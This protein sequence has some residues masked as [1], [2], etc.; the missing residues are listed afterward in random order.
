MSKLNKRTLGRS[1]IKVSPLGLGCWPIGGSFKFGGGRESSYGTVNDKE[2]IKAIQRA[3][4]LGVNFFDT[5]DVYGAG[6]SEELI[7]SAIK[8]YRDDIVIATK[9]GHLF[10]MKTKIAEGTSSEQD[11]IKQACEAS[12]KRLKT[13]YIDLYQLHLWQVPMNDLISIINTLDDLKSEGK[14]NSY[15]WSTD[16]HD[17]GEYFIKNSKSTAIQHEFNVLHDMKEIIN[18]CEKYN[19]ASINRTVLGMGL[20]SGKYTLDYSFP[21]ND[22]RGEKNDPDWIKYFN[23]GKPDPEWLK[24][25]DLIKDV[26][27]SD[28]RSMVQGAIAWNWARSEKTIPI[29]GFKS[30]K[31]VEENIQ[32]IEFGPLKNDQMKEI[33]EILG[34]RNFIYSID[35]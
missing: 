10:D 33:D 24:K 22:V 34:E 6:H 12:L 35:E 28:G 29:P 16:L 32:A 19:V 2:S 14:I 23:G 21:N 18:I 1:R 9:F 5:A 7:G 11:Y 17:L 25:L 3:I 30:I 20:L 31:Q 4:D 13:D 8:E 27:M 26:L 15:G